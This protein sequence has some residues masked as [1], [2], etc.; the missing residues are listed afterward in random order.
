MVDPFS[1]VNQNIVEKNKL[2]LF[3]LKDKRR[4]LI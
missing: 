1:K 4:K 2:M 3:E